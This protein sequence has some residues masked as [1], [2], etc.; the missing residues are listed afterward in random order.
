MWLKKY[1]HHVLL[2]R[3]CR[4]GVDRQSVSNYNLYRI[5]N[6]K[7][8]ETIINQTGRRIAKPR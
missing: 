7:L 1:P 6:R 8:S 2:E 4:K 3:K 5:A